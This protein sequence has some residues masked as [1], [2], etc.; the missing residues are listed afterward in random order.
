MSEVRITVSDEGGE[1]KNISAP[2]GA[3]F[4][5]LLKMNGHPLTCCN[6]KGSC[7]RCRIQFLEGAPLPTASDR[8]A[9]TPQQLRE[10]YRLACMHSAKKAC[11][12]REAFVHPQEVKI[13]S[14]YEGAALTN[15]APEEYVI[16]I[17]LGT[18]TIAMHAVELES[19]CAYDMGKS[20]CVTDTYSVQNPQRRWGSDVISRISEAKAGHAEELKAT[21]QAA[22]HTGIETLIKRAGR[23]PAKICL[24]GNTVMEHLFLGL[25]PSGLGEYPFTPV[26]LEEQRCGQI[27]LLPGISAYVGADILAGMLAC[28]FGRERKDKA[29]LLIDLGTNG[30]MALEYGDRLLCTATAA[31]PAFEGGASANVPGTDMVAILASLLQEGAMDDT[32]LLQG[33]YFDAGWKCGALCVR[34]QDIRALQMAK[35]AI[36]AGIELMLERMGISYDEVEEVYLA[37]GFGYYL[38]VNAAASIGLFPA[39]LAKK[40]RAVGNTALLGAA[41]YAGKEEMRTLAGELTARAEGMNLAEEEAF[42][43]LYLGNLNFD[44]A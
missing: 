12:I 4:L 30:E 31:G 39:D 14:S 7:G 19:I 27:C 8:L 13:L 25:D 17:D 44:N 1:E 5:Q 42:E 21:V 40:A 26:S 37:G 43:E 33:A 20:L 36:R 22:V 35:A 18:T 41:L 2:V 11:R 38:D 23:N 16:A 32:G 29:R 9:L 6:G 15:K 3:G 34:Q 10:G 28:G 24:A